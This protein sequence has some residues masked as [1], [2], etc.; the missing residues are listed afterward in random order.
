MLNDNTEVVHQHQ[1][2]VT[3]IR[4]RHMKKFNETKPSGFK[5]SS[6]NK[7]NKN[8]INNNDNNDHNNKMHSRSRALTATNIGVPLKLYNNRKLLTNITKSFNSDGTW[9]SGIIHDLT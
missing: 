6:N 5:I 9:T 8:G 1:M 4:L 2:V 3:W 7:S